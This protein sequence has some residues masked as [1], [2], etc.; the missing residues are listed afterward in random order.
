MP[1]EFFRQVASTDQHSQFHKEGVTSAIESRENIVSEA[2]LLAKLHLKL[3]NSRKQFENLALSR[4][5]IFER[6]YIST[7]EMYDYISSLFGNQKHNF[8]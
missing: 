7:E 5:S 6:T 1:F 4:P 2:K 8:R 3:W